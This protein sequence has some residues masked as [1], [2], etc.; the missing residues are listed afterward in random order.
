MSS[1]NFADT[2]LG[3]AVAQAVNDMA[4]QLDDS[5]SRLPTQVLNISGLVRMCPVIPSF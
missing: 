2:I 4:K 3:E 5:A 1:S